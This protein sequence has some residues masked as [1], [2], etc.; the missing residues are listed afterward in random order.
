MLS[1]IVHF[2]LAALLALLPWLSCFNVDEKNQ[3]SF[4]G[5][6]EDMFG[7]TV[8]QFEN[9]EGKWVLIG[10]PLTGQPAKRT[11]DVYRCPVGQNKNTGCEKFLL[12][13]NTTIP[14]INEVKENMTMGTTL[15]VNPDGNG[16]LACGPQY[17]YMCGKQQYITGICSNVSSSFK[18][19][20]SISPT[21]RECKQEMDVV[22]VLD[23]SN[24]IYPWEP[25]TEFLVKFLQ[26]IEIGPAR[27]GIVS[28]GDD[29]GHVFNLSQFSNTKDLLK[30]AANIPQRTG[31]K[32]MTALGIDT[33][34]KEAFTLERG[35]RPGVKKIMVIV[36]DGESHDHYNLKNVI[37]QCEE[38]GIER[39]AV[40]VLGDYNR[41][42]KSNEEIKK[43]ID[44]IEFIASEQ[45]SDHF[46]NVS[47]ERAL[48]TIVDALGSKIFA[49]EATSE[50]HT[51]S[52]EMEMS[53]AGFSAHT[54]KAGVM[55]GA[56]GA[57]DWNG[58]VVMQSGQEFVVPKKNTFQDPADQRY[59]GMAGYI[60]YDVQSAYTPDGVLYI[61]GAPRFNH[62]GRVTVYRFDGENATITQTLKGEQIG[63]YFGSVLQT[64][65]IDRDNYTDILLV[66]APMYMGPERDEQGQVYVY[67]LN[68]DGLFEHEM[69]LKPVNQTCC[70]AHSQS[71]CKSVSKNEPCGAR[72][73]TAIAAVPDLN[74]DGFSDIV[75]GSPLENDHRGAVYIYH[76]SQKSIK[77]KYV[78]RIAAGGDGESMKFFGQS[79]HGIMDLNDDGIIDVTIG[80]IGGAAL[81]WSRD[82]AELLAEMTFDPSKINLQQTCQ[83]QGRT[84]VCVKTKVCFK[85]R[86]KSDKD[87]NTGTVIRYSLT[88]DSLRAIAR[89]R[90]NETDNRRLQKNESIVDKLC[91]EHTFYTS[92]KLDFRDPIMVMLEF[93]LADG[94][95]GPVLD[96][97]LPT[98][99]N[100]T[101]ALVDCGNDDKCVANLHLKATA[102]ISRLLIK[103]N[104]EKFYVNVDIHNSR[105]NAY[106]TKVTLSHTKNINYVKVE[107]KDKDCETNHTRIVCAVGYPF[108]KNDKRESFKIQFEPNPSHIRKDIVINVTATTDSEEP[109]SDLK[110]NFVSI[111]I[112]VQHEA[113][114][115]FTANKYMK[116]DHIIFKEKETIPSVFNHTSVI[117]DKVKISYT[118]ERDPEMPSPP[119]L[120][121]IMFPYQTSVKNFLLYLTD[122]SHTAG[123]SCDASTLINPLGIKPDK[124]YTVIPKKETLSVYLLSCK[125]ERHPCKSFSCFIPPGDFNQIN[126]TFR[127]WR[128]TFIKGEFSNFHMAIDAKL[129]SKDTALFV[130]ND[131]VKIREVKI[132]VTKDIRSGIPLWIIILSIL[133]GLLILALVIF[134]LWKAGFFKRKSVEDMKEDMKDSN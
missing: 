18:V 16:F 38:D 25:I 26:S 13:E 89:G 45:K 90:F 102:N 84:T 1:G 34:R 64:H 12:P 28:Y 124:P 65:D 24:S 127:V 8:Q 4:S 87:T 98:S 108:L 23:G 54:S 6:V 130:L 107:P 113:N 99:L 92:D 111:V 9:S 85:Y 3:M 73:G 116:E 123:I 97:E 56:V 33:A 120:I 21:V 112:P 11:G 80:G 10:S 100:K 77:E 67:R 50:N 93:G 82:V 27:V 53:Q 86:I 78:Q 62:S 37:N 46:F 40:A 59:E 52:F 55:L 20:N 30:E 70:T 14:N 106:N 35:A 134:A 15:V 49:L 118:I 126:T 19:L 91:R 2:A 68:E 72:F 58:T 57:F 104:Q 29:V 47:D 74:L 39:F 109:D 110:D 75:I 48:V 42:N 95:S 115:R 7:Y 36:T 17:G 31:H 122:V 121:K 61:T 103:S 5:P 22:I 71:N 63:S 44:E 133:I 83:V 76:G 96:G 94:D 132:Q 105:D 60:G 114:L 117:G 32:T 128:P 125:E 41:Q 129:E 69:T 88:L 79:I 131:N 119:L 101:I 43:F 66:G 51:S 81:F